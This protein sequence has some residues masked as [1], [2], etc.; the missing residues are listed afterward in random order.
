M[1]KN[2][3]KGFIFASLP[4]AM[5]FTFSFAYGP[6][7]YDLWPRLKI[8]A[9]KSK[10]TWLKRLKKLRRKKGDNKILRGYTHINPFHNLDMKSDRDK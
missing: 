10:G 8:K 1:I 3:P 6:F 9:K 4:P 7:A 2:F 5:G